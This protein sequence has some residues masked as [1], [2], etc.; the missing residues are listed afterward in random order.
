MKSIIMNMWDLYKIFV[1]YESGKYIYSLCCPTSLESE[2]LCIIHRTSNAPSRKF[3]AFSKEI[4]S[5]VGVVSGL[6]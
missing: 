1:Q 4:M 5:V 6:T 3:K 2:Y